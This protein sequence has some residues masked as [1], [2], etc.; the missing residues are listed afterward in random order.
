MLVRS[1][2]LQPGLSVCSWQVCNPAEVLCRRR[3]P[4]RFNEAPELPFSAR[5]RCIDGAVICIAGLRAPTLRRWPLPLSEDEPPLPAA[6]PPTAYFSRM[7]DWSGFPHLTTPTLPSLSPCKNWCHFLKIF[8]VHLAAYICI[9]TVGGNAMT[10]VATIT[11]EEYMTGTSHLQRD[12]LP[13][14]SMMRLPFR[15][16][17]CAYISTR[18]KEKKNGSVLDHV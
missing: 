4:S 18:V 12:A 17:A 5:R 16:L 2:S 1:F 14:G 6:L 15:R 3:S 8:L 13:V 10:L 7:H 9:L 11:Q